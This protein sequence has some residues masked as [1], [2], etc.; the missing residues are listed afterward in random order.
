MFSS[1]LAFAGAQMT[2]ME[3]WNAGGWLM[4]VLLGM[5]VIVVAVC[6]Y[7]LVTLRKGAVVPMRLRRDLPKHLLSN[8]PNDARRAC[9]DSTSHLA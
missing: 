4:W 7:F 9:E 8:D 1:F 5:S 2:L 3:A 6:L